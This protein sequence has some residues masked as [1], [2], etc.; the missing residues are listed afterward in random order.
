MNSFNEFKMEI[1]RNPVFETK[2]AKAVFIG[3]EIVVFPEDLKPPDSLSDAV[4]FLFG[5]G[6]VAVQDRVNGYG[7]IRITGATYVLNNVRTIGAEWEYKEV[8][9]D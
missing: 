5:K 8:K 1:L 9:D 7:Y 4:K 2:I 6:A 3:Q